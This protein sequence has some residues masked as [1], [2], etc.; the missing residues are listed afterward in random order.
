MLNKTLGFHVW[1]ET[2]YCE[3]E[4][5]SMLTEHIESKWRNYQIVAIYRTIIT[6]I[7]V[8]EHKYETWGMPVKDSPFPDQ[9]SF[10]Q[11][12]NRDLPRLPRDLSLVAGK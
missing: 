12:E 9:S 2:G 1:S 10:R 4:T 8:H 5:F 3:S 11:R 7:E 6:K